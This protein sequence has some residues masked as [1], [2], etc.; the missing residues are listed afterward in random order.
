M[1]AVFNSGLVIIAAF[2]FID[3]AALPTYSPTSNAF[4][5][6]SLQF[7]PV[8]YLFWQKFFLCFKGCPNL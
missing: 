8:F 1:I 3:T 4:A 7:L 2:E 6:F 5:V